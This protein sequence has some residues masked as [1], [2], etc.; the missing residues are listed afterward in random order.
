[1]VAA[2]LHRP[3]CER[4]SE[5][6][7]SCDAPRRL[8]IKMYIVNHSNLLERRWPDAEL[9]GLYMWE[10]CVSLIEGSSSRCVS[11]TFRCELSLCSLTHHADFISTHRRPVTPSPF[12]RHDETST[13]LLYNKPA[14]CTLHT[15]ISVRE[16]TVRKICG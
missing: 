6:M 9:L 4:N 15:L 13:S 12:D 1:M 16:G 5:T 2:I 11:K 7:V 3:T 8:H 10:Y 14:I